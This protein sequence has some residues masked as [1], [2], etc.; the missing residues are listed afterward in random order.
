LV[1]TG[2]AGG[3]GGVDGAGVGEDSLLEADE[4]DLVELETLGAVEGHEDDGVLVLVVLVVVL[5]EGQ[6]GE[7]VVEG[8]GVPALG[9]VVLRATAGVVVPAAS[10]RSAQ[11]RRS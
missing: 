9:R 6:A 7:G 1:A 10:G 8:G 2:I 11:R 4:E 3:P 5:V